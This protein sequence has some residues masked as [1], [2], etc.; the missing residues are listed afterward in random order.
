ME[1]PEARTPCA[2]HREESPTEAS[3][4]IGNGARVVA[5]RGTDKKHVDG[6][7]PMSVCCKEAKRVAM[8]LSQGGRSVKH[9]FGLVAFAGKLWGASQGE[10]DPPG[11]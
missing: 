1:S 8:I 7:F 6:P 3:T 5:G 2:A 4:H 10:E 9:V 11:E